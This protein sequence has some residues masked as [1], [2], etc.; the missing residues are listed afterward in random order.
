MKSGVKPP[1]SI[2]RAKFDKTPSRFPRKFVSYLSHQGR[3]KVSQMTP[4]LDRK[5]LPTDTPANHCRTSCGPGQ[6]TPAPSQH[7]VSNLQRANWPSLLR[8]PAL[9]ACTIYSDEKL[10]L[11]IHS[12]THR[13]RHAQQAA[14]PGDR[15]PN[16]TQDI[17]QRPSSH[18]PGAVYGPANRKT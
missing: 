11:S 9:K 13:S 12:P 2:F 7:K 8:L 3:L 1:H 17:R 4:A 14:S 5:T 10:S 16:V 6:N 18:V 15:Q